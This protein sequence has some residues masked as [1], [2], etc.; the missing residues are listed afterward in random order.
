MHTPPRGAACENARGDLDTDTSNIH[1]LF[2]GCQSIQ[3]PFFRAVGPT[4]LQR[5]SLPSS[6][7]TPSLRGWVP[8]CVRSFSI[9]QF[10]LLQNGHLHSNSLAGLPGARHEVLYLRR[11]AQN[12]ALRTCSDIHCHCDCQIIPRT[13]TVPFLYGLREARSPPL[14]FPKTK[15]SV[16]AV[17]HRYFEFTR[18]LTANQ[19]QPKVHRGLLLGAHPLGGLGSQASALH[20]QLQFEV[21][22][23]SWV[24]VLLS[25]RP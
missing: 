23:P 15:A 24:N 8:C 7:L 14:A 21:S 17:S 5:Q 25:G 19:R 22:L 10:L 3:N 4:P 11:E 9:S 18:R 2:A 20:S 16:F 1:S 12:P 13:K 6:A